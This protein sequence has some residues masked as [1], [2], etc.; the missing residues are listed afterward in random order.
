MKTQFVPLASAIAAFGLALAASAAPAAAQSMS[1][2]VD[3]SDLDL[4]SPQGQATLDKRI[5]GAARKI[6][7]GDEQRTGTRIVMDSKMRACIA[8]VKASTA[9]QVATARQERQLGG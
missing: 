8:E 7:G 6:C 5:A 1:I 9:Q 4:T 2:D 3:Y